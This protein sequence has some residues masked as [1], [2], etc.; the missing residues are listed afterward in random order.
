MNLNA[1]LVYV[2]C[3]VDAGKMNAGIRVE[4]LFANARCQYQTEYASNSTCKPRSSLICI[5]KG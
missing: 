5:R 2:F 1:E 3:L 4:W